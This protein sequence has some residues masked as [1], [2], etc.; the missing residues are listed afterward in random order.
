MDQLWHP[1]SMIMIVFKFDGLS[2]LYPRMQYIYIYL[3][4]VQQEKRQIPGI[5]QT[6]LAADILLTQRFCNWADSFLPFRSLRL[7]Y[8]FLEVSVTSYIFEMVTVSLWLICSHDILTLLL[9]H[10]WLYWAGK[11]MLNAVKFLC[12]RDSFWSVVLL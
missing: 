12:F 5:L 11:N 8:K 4:Q 1:K 10:L 7:H 9:V 2:N 3:F 6:I